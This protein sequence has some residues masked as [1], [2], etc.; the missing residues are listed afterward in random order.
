M[1]VA[2]L[3]GGR[4]NRLK[5]I[6]DHTPKPMIFIHGKP[7]L[8]CQLE[9]IK[10]FGLIDIVLLVGH[11]G[12]HIEDYFGNGYKFGLNIEYSY[13]TA[14]LGTGGALKNAEDKLDDEFLLLNGDTYLAIDYAELTKYFHQCKKLGMLTVYSNRERKI[15]NNIGID[16][17]NLI[18]DYNKKDSSGMTYIDAGAMV[19]K[20]EIL[21]IIPKNKVYSLE[22]GVFCKLIAMK[23]L[24]AFP[25]EQKFYDIGSPEGLKALEAI[26]R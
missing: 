11:L 16:N 6:T 8:Q 26:L 2:I 13:E 1:Q 3:A 21:N 12:N 7:F 25:I 14:L 20:K 19:F 10:S 17:L 24:A 18:I 22:E 9:F 23:E 4:G 15:P 5:P